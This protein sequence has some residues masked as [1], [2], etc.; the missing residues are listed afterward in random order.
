MFIDR[1]RFFD[2]YRAE[3]GQLTQAKVDGLNTLLEFVESDAGWNDLRQLAYFFATI[4]HEA[5]DTW[6]PIE[7]YGKG[8]KYTYGKADSQ[9]GHAYYGRGYTQTTWKENYRKVSAAWNR[10][11]PDDPVDFVANPE[12]LLQ[13]KFSYFATAHCMRTGLYTGKSLDDYI[14]ESRCD[15]VNARRI[16]NGLDKAQRIADYAKDFEKILRSA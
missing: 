10:L 6:E 7:E 3:F 4:K 5:A 9:T 14:N 13:P 1:K 8:K 15:Y 16:I 2:G 12:L 11:N